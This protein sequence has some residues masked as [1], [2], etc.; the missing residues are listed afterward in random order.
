MGQL[1]HHSLELKNLYAECTQA[2]AECPVAAKFHHLRAAKHRVE[3]F[4]TPLSRSVLGLTAL[5]AFATKVG[6]KRRGRREGVAA[7]VFLNSMNPH[8]VLL[9]A[10]MADVGH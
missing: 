9:A 3:T 10:L 2:S 6:I 8:L 7:E 4:M 5:L 1:I